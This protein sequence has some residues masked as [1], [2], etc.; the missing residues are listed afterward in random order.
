M[1]VAQQ[2]AHTLGARCADPFERVMLLEAVPADHVIRVLDGGRS[3]QTR[4]II[5]TAECGQED[6]LEN[7]R[8]GGGFDAAA[9]GL[10]VLRPTL[11]ARRGVDEGSLR[12]NCDQV[13]L[14]S[15]RLY[16]HLAHD[17]CGARVAAPE[18]GNCKRKLGATLCS[19]HLARVERR[20]LLALLLRLD[21]SAARSG[22]TAC[23]TVSR[24]TVA[25]SAS[26]LS[27][28]HRALLN[29]PAARGLVC[30]HIGLVQRA[31]VILG[32]RKP[33]DQLLV[34]LRLLKVALGAGELR[35]EGPKLRVDKGLCPDNALGPRILGVPP[36]CAVILQRP[37][38]VA[39][40]V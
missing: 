3:A 23:A 4:L 12:G 16:R 39:V 34:R 35:V 14:L 24:S 28:Q 31:H 38:V 40:Q 13:N 26:R 7:D 15:K 21:P 22:A 20:L 6:V 37:R 11:L 17:E 30:R 1:G 8:H 27:S 18:V 36:Q 33:K 5:A 29:T 19:R 10:D 2:R 32:A 9:V 25:T